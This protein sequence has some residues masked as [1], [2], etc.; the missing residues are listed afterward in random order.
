MPVYS[1][2]Q[3]KR[4]GIVL[5]MG[6]SATVADRD[7]ALEVLNYWRV[8]HAELLEQATDKLKEAA[9]AVGCCKN[10]D[11]LSGELPLIT[12]RLKRADTIIGKL[13]RQDCSFRLNTMYDI[14][15]C[16]MVV[17]SIDEVYWVKDYLQKRCDLLIREKKGIID[18]IASPKDS[19][20]RSLHIVALLNDECYGYKSLQCEMQVR[21]E[22]EHSWATALETYDVVMSNKLKF[23]GG[24]PR[25]RRF[26]ALASALFASYEKTGAVPGT[27]TKREEIIKELSH[28]ERECNILARLSAYSNS[29]STVNTLSGLGSSG[30]CVLNVNYEEQTTECHVFPEDQVSD[31][32]DLYFEL[33][34]KKEAGQDV[35]QVYMPKI[36]E[37]SDAYPNYSSDISFFLTSINSSLG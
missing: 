9:N 29:V 23:G 27:P 30:Y 12:G 15:G 10:F 5:A 21:T 17:A 20:Y 34:R 11:G 19:G 3:V 22:L 18:Y 2:N 14:I 25:E 35:L 28:I 24:N 1:R 13:R 4:A 36:G 32:S 16:R 31:A 33:E 26:F 37:L 8:A 7:E 6:E